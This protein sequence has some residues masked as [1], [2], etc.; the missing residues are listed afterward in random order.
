MLETLLERFHRHDRL[1]LARLVSLVARGEQ[2]EAILAGVG[3]PARPARVVGVHHAPASRMAREKF[4]RFFPL[5]LGQWT[6]S[7]GC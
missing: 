2:E 3:E 6:R 1:A 4:A 7:R 5:A